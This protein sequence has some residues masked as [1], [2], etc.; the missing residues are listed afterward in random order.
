MDAEM[1][2]PRSLLCYLLG[3]N[4]DLHTMRNIL[5]SECSYSDPISKTER[6]AVMPRSG[7]L[8]NCKACTFIPN[9]PGLREQLNTKQNAIKNNE[10][11]CT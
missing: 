7:G 8:L 2:A 6:C 5:S 1:F 3:S 10:I 9:Q 4:R 11:N